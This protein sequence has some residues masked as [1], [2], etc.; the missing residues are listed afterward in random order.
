MITENVPSESRTPR[1]SRPGA[2]TVAALTAAVGSTALLA[3]GCVVAVGNSTSRWDRDHPSY[4][5]S[6]HEFDHILH[7]TRGVEVG[8][9]RDEVLDR[10]EP[11]LL[12]KFSTIA[13]D[14]ATVEEWRVR[15]VRPGSF[16]Q[17]WFYFVDGRLVA[18]HD[19]RMDNDDLLRLER[20]WLDD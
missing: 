14:N 18:F 11:R 8:M 16:H 5:V 13:L 12:A 3:S 15:A 17:R 2:K 4:R 7:A 1:R 9:T 19:E 6:G 20:A 10:Y